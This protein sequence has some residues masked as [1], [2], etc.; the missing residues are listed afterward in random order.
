VSALPET[1][2]ASQPLTWHAGRHKWDEHDGY[3][4][5]QHSINGALT[6][7]PHDSHPHFRGDV[8][9]RQGIDM[10]EWKEAEA[11]HVWRTADAVGNLLITY[12]RK[13]SHQERQDM[14]DAMQVLMKLG[15]KIQRG[16][17]KR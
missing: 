2:P 9:Q 8:F 4:R 14:S 17:I 13:L 6:I 1:A 7:D 10:P 11:E 5:H 12:R 3:P 15:G 16:E